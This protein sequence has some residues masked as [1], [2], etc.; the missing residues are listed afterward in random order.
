MGLF[1]SPY[2]APTADIT[3]DTPRKKGVR[4]LLE[5]I[6][7][8]YWRFFAAGWLA[9][10]AALPP[11]VGVVFGIF[12]QNLAVVLIAGCLGGVL[13]APCFCGCMDTVLRSLRDEPNYWW[14]TWRRVVKENARRALA[15]GAGF[16]TLL[17]TQSFALTH[18]LLHGHSAVQGIVLAGLL[19]CTALMLCCFAQLVLV[20]CSL[21]QMLK[22]AVLF[23]MGFAPQ[24]LLAAAIWLGGAWL[25]GALGSAAVLPVLL[26]SFWLPMLLACFALYG[27]L[28]KAFHLFDLQEKP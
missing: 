12:A 15:L 10:L 8:D 1:A 26:G 20:R 24:A 11:V 7:R 16:G 21:G 6:C 23:T 17:A 14:H 9:L 5:V 4:R 25:V 3:P 27:A 2:T 19:V 22:N 13:A 18:P 28:E